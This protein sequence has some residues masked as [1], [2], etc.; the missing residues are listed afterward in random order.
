[1]G[2]VD[3]Q[4]CANMSPVDLFGLFF[5]EYLLRDIVAETNRYAEQCRQVAPKKGGK[6]MPWEDMV[7]PKLKTWLGLCLEWDWCRRKADLQ[8][9]GQHTG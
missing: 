5:T 1:M 3:S 2:V 9:T 8:T 4:R 7:V 6:H